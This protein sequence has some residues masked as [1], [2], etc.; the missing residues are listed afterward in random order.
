MALIGNMTVVNKSNSFFSSGIA[1]ATR[2]NF[3]NLSYNFSKAKFF[4]DKSSLGEGYDVIQVD[5][6]PIKPGGMGSVNRCEG[7]AAA[8]AT[9]LRVAAASGTVAGV[10]TVTATLKAITTGTGAVTGAATVTGSASASSSLSGTIAGVATATATMKA[11]ATLS[12]SAEGVASVS[13]ILS[14]IAHASG[15]IEIGAAEGLTAGAVSSAVW[16]EIIES[17]YSSAEILKVL[18]AFAAGKTS[19]TALGG[20]DATVVFRDLGDT[21][22]RI[23][24]GME[25]SERT[26]VT[27]DTV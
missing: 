10:A 2:S 12:G 21:K 9:A 14:G 1:G 15:T 4:P 26:T 6:A 22:D 20:G 8:T 16:S 19:I 18:A 3:T 23:E 13:A 5:F 11:T 7:V 27:L 25:G 24:A 17:G